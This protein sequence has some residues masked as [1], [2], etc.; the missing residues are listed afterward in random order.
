MS[1]TI[2]LALIAKNEE[3]QLPTLLASIDGAFDQV[4]LLDTGSD[5]RTVEVFE[6]WARGQQQQEHTAGPGEPLQPMFTWSTADFEWIDDFA[7]ARRAADELLTTDWTCWADCDDEIRG[8][9]NLRGTVEQTPAEIAGLVFGYEYAHDERGT[10]LCYLKRERL[11]RRGR[12]RW[13]GRVH[14]AQTVEGPLS[15]IPPEVACWIHRAP[16][17]VVSDSNDRNLRILTKWVEEEPENPR[18]LGYL[19][20]EELVRGRMADALTYFERYLDLKTGWDEERAQVHRKHAICLISEGRYD[21]AIETA[22]RALQVMPRWPDSYLSLAEAYYQRQEFDKAA[23]WARQALEKGTPDTLLII[24]PLDYSFQPRMVLASALGAMGRLDEAIDLAEEALELLPQHQLLAAGVREW[25]AIRK[26]EQTA[27]TWVAAA[28][29]LVSHDEQLKAADLLETVPHYA[30]D[31]PRVVATR[32]QL[33]A[34]LAQ[35]LDPDSYADHYT[36]G[37]SK[38]EDMVPDE[39]VDETAGSLPRAHFLLEGIDDQLAAAA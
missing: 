3:E 18:V 24:N 27:Q 26:R 12:G 31:H 16:G 22:M 25:R 34:R 5:D 7:A 15:E 36:S 9:G 35:L 1:E 8:A 39:K 14:E 6:E 20:T 33:R 17:D 13:D 30:I 10:V 38:P 29:M 4:V 2:G 21:E 23:E 32:A 37:G 11:V 28:E 19:G